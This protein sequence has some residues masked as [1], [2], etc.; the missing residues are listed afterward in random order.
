MLVR[1]AYLLGANKP[2]SV[3]KK[4]KFHNID[5]WCC[6][7]L[8]T[9]PSLT[10][11]LEEWTT[12]IREE[13]TPLSFHFFKFF[14]KNKLVRLKIVVA[15]FQK[16]AYTLRIFTSVSW[17]NDRVTRRLK[18]NSPNFWKFGQNFSQNSKKYWEFKTSPLP[19]NG[20][21]Q[22]MFWTVAHVHV[23]SRQMAKFLPIWSHCPTWKA[24]VFV[25]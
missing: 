9:V 17:P 5:T 3:T 16:E 21:K 24:S 1:K 19:T 23:K 14:S 25:G 2:L 6:S 10:S 12:W 22:T 13:T 15:H 4:K 20:S 8:P 11:F 18:R 7:M